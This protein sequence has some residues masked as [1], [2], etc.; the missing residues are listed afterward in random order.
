MNIALKKT[1]T[2]LI[3]SAKADHGQQFDLQEVELLTTSTIPGL[4]PPI[5][6][7]NWKGHVLQYDVTSYATLHYY[8]SCQLSQTLILQIVQQSIEI[9]QQMKQSYCNYDNLILSF[10]KIYVDL[11][12]HSIRFIYVPLIVPFCEDAI[13]SFFHQ[14]F[15]CF[16]THNQEQAEFI[17]K[18]KEYLMSPLTFSLTDFA[19]FVKD[20]YAEI[21]QHHLLRLSTQ[22]TILLSS[23]EFTI[24]VDADAVDYCIAGT[25]FVSRQHACFT[26]Q[27]GQCAVTDL[28]SKNKTYV[29]QEQLTPHIRVLLQHGDII[30]LAKEEFQYL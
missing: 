4:I 22:E 25:P 3:C 7:Q 1:G 19:N 20:P 5:S 28:D 8:L 14:L 13:H 21:Q 10:D 24:G 11:K 23:A 30:R 17:A 9:F 2:Q 15:S 27:G 18:C 26:S 12:D 16:Q 29:N 6:M